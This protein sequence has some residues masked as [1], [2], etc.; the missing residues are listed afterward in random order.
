M[1]SSR[2]LLDVFQ[3]DVVADPPPSLQTKHETQAKLLRFVD[4]NR[5]ELNALMNVLIVGSVSFGTVFQ[6]IE[7]DAD[8]RTGWTW[9]EILRNIPADNLAAYQQS[10]FDNPVPT[11]ACTSGVAY[12]LG[13][14]TCQLS[15]GKTIATVD[16]RRSLRSG[17][18]GF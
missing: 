6:V 2:F 10:V 9:W 3:N 16:L 7:V 11:K 4:D 12:T 15:Q 13:D 8:I 17:I 1:S 5:I 18:A 14:F